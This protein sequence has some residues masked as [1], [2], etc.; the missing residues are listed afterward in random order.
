MKQ[1]RNRLNEIEINS[2]A[3]FQNDALQR[4]KYAEILTSVI[5]CYSSTGCVLAINGKWGTGKTT[6]VRMWRALLSQRGYNTLFFNAWESDYMEDPLVALVSEVRE[7]KADDT[8]F[9]EVAAN[10]GKIIL[11][12]AS[13]AL[14]SFVKSKIGIDCDTVTAAIQEAEGIGKKSLDDYAEQ[15]KTFEEF[16]NNLQA[17]IVDKAENKPVVFFI[18][19]LDRCR[20][21]YFVKVLERIKH[22]FDIPNIVFVLSINKQQLGFAIQ[23]FYGSAK[24]DADDYLRRFIDVEYEIPQ[25]KMEDVV[26]YLYAQHGFDD[27]FRNQERLKY[28]NRA[29]EP[30][31]FLATS[32]KFAEICNIDI[33]T[34]DRIF[35][36]SRIT[37][38]EMN[39]NNYLLP[40]VLFVLCLMKIKYQ[41]IYTGIV[42]KTYTVQALLSAIEENILKS[43]RV[44]RKS[45]QYERR[46]EYTIAT[47]ITNY[48]NPYYEE[49]VDN[50]FV[51]KDTD[52]ERIK[53]YPFVT[54]KLDQEKLNEAFNWCMNNSQEHLHMG[55]KFS[56]DRIDILNALHTIEE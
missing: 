20:P 13:S 35:A 33:R 6:F 19:E 5:D 43:Y 56:T 54:T 11:A 29:D 30:G 49:V 52:Q 34:L 26:N 12:T 14:T 48:N 10:V 39:A 36:I 47:L 24:L 7:L 41:D 37:L 28:F 53:N 21:D 45:S 15:K 46:L 44:D 17:Y 8:K 1:L 55:L 23:G 4:K 40:D 2:E 16:R 32:T 9:K 51:G 22:L 27:F 18:D 38:Q 50:T 31:E 3:P 25:P 42:R